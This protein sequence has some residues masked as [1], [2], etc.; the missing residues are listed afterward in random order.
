MYTIGVFA[1]MWHTYDSTLYPIWAEKSDWVGEYIRDA[2]ATFDK[3]AV[4]QLDTDIKLNEEFLESKEV[5]EQVF[6]GVDE[7]ISM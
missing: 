6:E 1:L 3:D 4:Q 2:W 7:D 5:F